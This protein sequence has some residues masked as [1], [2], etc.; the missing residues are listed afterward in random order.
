MTV[1]QAPLDCVWLSNIPDIILGSTNPILITIKIA[2][3]EKIYEQTLYPIDNKIILLDLE[4][5]VKNYC[6]DNLTKNAV[7]STPISIECRDNL[8][9]EGCDLDFLVVYAEGYI[10]MEPVDFCMTHFL[11]RGFQK[12]ITKLS[13]ELVSFVIPSN[14][15]G[16]ELELRAQ[17]NYL[18][19]GSLNTAVKVLFS[20]TNSG[21]WKINQ[22]D[23]SYQRIAALLP[24]ESQ[25]LSYSIYISPVQTKVTY[26]SFSY[27]LNPDVCFFYENF[28]FRNYFGVDEIIQVPGVS[29]IQKKYEKQSAMISKVKSVYQSFVDKS[30]EVTTAI[31]DSTLADP[32]EDF[33]SAIYV[34]AFDSITGIRGEAVIVEDITDESSNDIEELISYKFTYR[35]AKKTSRTDYNFPQRIFTQEYQHQFN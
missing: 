29:K 25:I 32:I 5:I 35:F 31:V 13:R 14:Q 26:H 4:A 12:H 24:P 8:A 10:A 33:F 6:F 23:C 17:C 34:W 19:D 11:T 7:L 9:I 27:F 16:D 28:V 18:I 22:V 1:I 3:D 30:V 15:D 21:D 20:T 2:S